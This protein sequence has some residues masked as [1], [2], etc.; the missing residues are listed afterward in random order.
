MGQGGVNL[1]INFFPVQ[2]FS[3]GLTNFYFMKQ[4]MSLIRWNI[5]FLMGI[6]II[7]CNYDDEPKE[8][9]LKVTD[10]QL[11]YQG[12]ISDKSG[13]KVNVENDTAKCLVRTIFIMQGDTLSSIK[14]TLLNDNL[15]INIITKPYDILNWDDISQLTKVHDIRFDLVGLKKGTYTIQ[16]SVNNAG[17]SKSGY[18]VK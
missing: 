9:S 5:L 17:G 2:L 15:S 7:S 16:L 10:A 3:N 12:E 6:M 14:A 13:F 1:C 18:V 4:S 11:I 8:I